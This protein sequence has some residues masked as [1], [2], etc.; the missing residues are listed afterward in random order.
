MIFSGF[1]P[2]PLSFFLYSPFKVDDRFQ[3]KENFLLMQQN[4]FFPRKQNIINIKL[5]FLFIFKMKKNQ[6]QFLQVNSSEAEFKEFEPLH[7]FKRRLKYGL[8]HLKLYS[9]F[10]DLNRRS[11]ETGFWDF[12]FIRFGHWLIKTERPWGHCPT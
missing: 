12:W 7:K 5:I 2:Y 1:R 10:Q 8:F 11:I 6:W 4:S 3:W 9:M